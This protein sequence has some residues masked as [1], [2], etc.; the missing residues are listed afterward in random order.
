[1]ATKLHVDDGKGNSYN[2]ML[3][4]GITFPEYFA[5]DPVER[6]R[7]VREMAGRD[8]D[9]VIVAYPKAGIYIYS[10]IIFLFYSPTLKKGGYTMPCPLVILSLCPSVMLSDENFHRFS[11]EL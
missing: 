5:D 1:M 8:D 10:H 4:D 7:D 6:L 2:L 9:V 3:V 11:Q